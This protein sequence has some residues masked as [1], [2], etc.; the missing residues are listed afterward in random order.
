[1]PIE[2]VET[3]RMGTELIARVLHDVYG[4]TISKTPELMEGGTENAAWLVETDQG[5]LIAKIFSRGEGDT[6]W[7]SDEAQLYLFLNEN[8][9]HV[10]EISKSIKE[11]SIETVSFNG[12]DFPLM[13][14]KYENLRMATPGIVTRQELELVAKQTAKMHQVLRDYPNLEVI[15]NRQ[16]V[17]R[18]EAERRPIDVV[19][20]SK[21]RSF[22]QEQLDKFRAIEDKMMNYLDSHPVVGILS[23]TIIHADLSLEH[24]RFLPNGEV[25]FFDFADRK[26]G[27][28][29]EELGTFVETLYQWENISFEKWEELKTAFLDAYF[30]VNELTDVDKKA[31]EGRI[32]IRA[33]GAIRYLAGLTKDNPNEGID[34]WIRKGYELG[35]YLVDKLSSRDE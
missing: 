21:A 19:V 32:L 23:E 3:K 12:F 31:I 9:V 20:E 33:M 29:A 26:W 14:M 35:D 25:Y 1:M 2:Y 17:D 10:P 28:I 30:D 27:T 7:I 13:I 4:L 15:R 22:N 5:K 34:H 6:D 16:K 24:T 18:T 11:N 8:G